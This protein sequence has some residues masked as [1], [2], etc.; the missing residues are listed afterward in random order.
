M[1]KTKG[2]PDEVTVKQHYLHSLGNW[3]DTAPVEIIY[4]S[5]PVQVLYSI[6]KL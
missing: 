6:G 2:T 5:L 3:A 1:H 4:L